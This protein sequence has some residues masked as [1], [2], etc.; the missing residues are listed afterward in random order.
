MNLCSL[1]WLRPNLNLVISLIPS[2]LR[3]S[4]TE[5]GEC[6]MKLKTEILLEFL[7]LRSKLFHSIIA[8]GK[9]RIF[10][11]VML[12]LNKGNIAFSSGSI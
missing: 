5:F 6:R 10:E 3:I 12:C 2:G 9:K 7:R 8:D 4:K 1:K 11:K